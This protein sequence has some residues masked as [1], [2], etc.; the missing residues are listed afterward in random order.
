MIFNQVEYSIKMTN[1]FLVK[2][3]MVYYLMYLPPTYPPTYLF[4]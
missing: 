4:S 2:C 1:D 3:D